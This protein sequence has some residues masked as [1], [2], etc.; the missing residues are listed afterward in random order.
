[1][2]DAN[3]QAHNLAEILYTSDKKPYVAPELKQQAHLRDI[4]LGGSPG[5]G[6]T[7][8]SSG[9]SPYE[10]YGWAKQN[11]GDSSGGIFDNDIFEG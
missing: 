9:S 8:L 10:C 1:M 6:E 11:S 4:T 2:N 5:P 7:D 3:N